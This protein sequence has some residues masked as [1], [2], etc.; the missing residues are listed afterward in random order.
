M[1]V[2]EPLVAPERPLKFKDREHLRSYLIQLH[3]YYDVLNRPRF[4]GRRSAH[5]LTA[6]AN[7][8]EDQS[9]ESQE[10]S[11]APSASHRRWHWH[12]FA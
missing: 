2:E 1:A 9:T 7:E 10:G 5:E 11:V 8:N 6:H 3:K 12:G 4:G